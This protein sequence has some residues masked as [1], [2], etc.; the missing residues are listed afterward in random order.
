MKTLHALTAALIF[1]LT[2]PAYAAANT[3]SETGQYKQQV[4]ISTPQT[5]KA[6]PATIKTVRN[7]AS[8][9]RIRVVRKSLPLRPRSTPTASKGRLIMVPDTSNDDMTIYRP[10]T[11]VKK[12][13][14]GMPNLY[15]H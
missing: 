3:N 15:K 8:A 5:L 12:H 10:K 1:T 13:D 4:V 6:A 2:C 9:P 7:V 11:S 14:R